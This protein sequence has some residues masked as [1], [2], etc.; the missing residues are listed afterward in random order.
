[1]LR[2]LEERTTAPWNSVDEEEIDL[3]DMLNQEGP[4]D[5][6]DSA[7]AELVRETPL[8]LLFTCSY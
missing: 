3:G 2:H 4:L 6:D 8:Y 1:M 7:E 5:R